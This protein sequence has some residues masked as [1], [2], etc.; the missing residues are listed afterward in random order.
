MR[1][2]LR[3]LYENGTMRPIE[4]VLRMGEGKIYYNNFV[5]ITVVP[6]TTIIC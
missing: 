4:T 3:I 5:N 2:V 6:S 1:E